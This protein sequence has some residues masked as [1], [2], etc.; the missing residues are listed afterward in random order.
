MKTKSK[1][2]KRLSNEQAQLESKRQMEQWEK[3]VR[4]KTK[5]K[6]KGK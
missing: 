4:F 2:C 5:T 3:V 6:T 1:S